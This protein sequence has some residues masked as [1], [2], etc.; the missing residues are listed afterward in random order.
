MMWPGQKPRECQKANRERRLKM[1][2]IRWLYRMKRVYLQ[3]QL[4]NQLRINP[5]RA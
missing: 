4:K 3:R 2:Q 5:V 1:I